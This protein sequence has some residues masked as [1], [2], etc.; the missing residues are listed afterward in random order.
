[1]SVYCQSVAKLCKIACTTT[2]IRLWFASNRWDTHGTIS[3]CIQPSALKSFSQSAA[4][5]Q[6]C[7]RVSL[8]SLPL[9]SLPTPPPRREATPL[10]RARW[11]GERCKLPQRG[12][13]GAEARRILLHCML[14]KRIW[15]QN[16]CFLS[17]HSNVQWLVRSK[18]PPPL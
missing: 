6:L 4:L 14:A 11:S 1:M 5:L 12:P 15:L 7:I 8:P 3:M 17:Q 2:T 10:K 13:S 9:Y 16:F 18:V